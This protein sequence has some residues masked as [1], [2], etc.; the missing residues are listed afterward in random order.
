MFWRGG[1][2]DEKQQPRENQ[3]PRRER[4]R[5]WL[6][7]PKTAQKVKES[8][9]EKMSVDL[10]NPEVTANPPC[11]TENGFSRVGQQAS[12][13]KGAWKSGMQTSCGD[14]SLEK[15]RLKESREIK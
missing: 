10:V 4:K 9:E 2:E 3:G 12:G 6:V 13:L 15:L 1:A 5:E 14:N 11:G 8:E 7:Q